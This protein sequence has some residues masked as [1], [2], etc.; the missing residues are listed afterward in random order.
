MDK[1][2]SIFEGFTQADN[3]MTRKFGGTGL[4]PTI[5]SRLVEAMGGTHLV[6]SQAGSGST[7]HFNAQFGL[8]KIRSPL[9]E[10]PLPGLADLPV[11][12]VDGN[13]T[14]RHLLQRMLKGW[15]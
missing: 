8:Q 4:G 3:S 6:E 10:L 15:G 13:A 12:I 1:Q 9:E 2:H 7:F 14:S 5:S 11:L